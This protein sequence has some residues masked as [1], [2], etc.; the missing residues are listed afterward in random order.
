MDLHDVQP[1]YPYA[2]SH[3]K[4]SSDPAVRDK[5]FQQNPQ[6]ID[7][8]VMSNKM[9]QAMQQ[10]GPGEAYILNALSTAKQIWVLQRGDVK[11]EIYQVQK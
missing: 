6:N 8:I 10:N 5:L 7:Y 4:A 2:H 1:I 9:L 3:W 11:L